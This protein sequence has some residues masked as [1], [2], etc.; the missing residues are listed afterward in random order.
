MKIIIGLL[1]LSLL[2]VS[3]SAQ[4]LPI[5]KSNIKS[6]NVREGRNLYKGYWNV[7]PEVKKDI[8]FAHRFKETSIITF[9]S[10]VAR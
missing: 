7:S 1:S 4:K 6:I 8:Y 10:D 2:S 9:Y 5:L 3:V